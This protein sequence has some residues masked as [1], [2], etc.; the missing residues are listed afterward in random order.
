MNKNRTITTYRIGDKVMHQNYIH[1][2]TR[3]FCTGEIL[4]INNSSLEEEYEQ[5]DELEKKQYNYLIK[6][7]VSKSYTTYVYSKSEIKS[8]IA[9]K[10]I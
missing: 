4:N 3:E 8:L 7:H 1:S 2:I 10:I 6:V 5:D 9:R